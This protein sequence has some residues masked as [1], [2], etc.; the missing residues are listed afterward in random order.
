MESTGNGCGFVANILTPEILTVN[1]GMV[2][3]FVDLHP[4][5]FHGSQTLD[6]DV[7]T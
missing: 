1:R 7:E 5:S 3:A 6:R 4:A 2:Q